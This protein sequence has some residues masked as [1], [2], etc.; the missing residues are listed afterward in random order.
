MN[1][2]HRTQLESMGR[3]IEKIA[4]KAKDTEMCASIG[5]IALEVAKVRFVLEEALDE[6]GKKV[7]DI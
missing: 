7:D 6:C 3:A 2:K 1:D 5:L 4:S